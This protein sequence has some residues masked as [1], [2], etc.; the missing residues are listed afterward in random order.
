[1]AFNTQNLKQALLSPFRAMVSRDFYFSVLFGMKGSGFLYIFLLCA[2]LA[3][4]GSIRTASVM[5]YFK[6]LDLPRLVVQIPASYLDES[7]TLSPND[8]NEA[9][10]EIKNQSGNLVMVYNTADKPLSGAA[11]DAPI[12]FNSKDMVFHNIKGGLSLPY[13]GL[14][15]T[16]TTFQPVQSAQMLEGVLGAGPLLI[17][18]VI[19]LSMYFFLIFNAFVTACLARF[20]M[21]FIFRIRTSFGATLRLSSYANTLVAFIMLAQFFVFLPMSYTIMALVPLIYIALF[22]QRFRAE[23]AHDGIENFARRY[24]GRARVQTQ[25]QTNADESRPRDTSVYSGNMYADEQ[26]R[27]KREAQEQEKAE[28]TQNSGQDQNKDDEP[29]N[30][31]DRDDLNSADP[32]DNQ[33]SPHDAESNAN[34]EQDSADKKDGDQN[35]KGSGGGFFEA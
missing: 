11:A 18:S 4:P 3:I 19:M 21:L 24:G 6:S 23:L 10:K 27:L 14:F 28:K 34:S 33:P 5:H 20:M 30:F 32:D 16:G 1:M 12:E 13:V 9:Y 29:D 2:A 26:E 35:N 8:Q 17:W 22:S 15:Q 31:N 7:G 25:V